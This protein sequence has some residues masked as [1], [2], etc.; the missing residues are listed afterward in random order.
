MKKYIME[1]G[2]T[3]KR[4]YISLGKDEDSRILKEH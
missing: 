4:I 2:L 1:I 3:G